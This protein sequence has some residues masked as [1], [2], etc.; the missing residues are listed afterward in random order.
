VLVVRLA[1]KA[2]RLSLPAQ[3]SPTDAVITRKK[4]TLRYG[5]WMCKTA[6]QCKQSTLPS[7]RLSLW[8]KSG[9]SGAWEQIVATSPLPM[10]VAL[11]F[12]AEIFGTRPPQQ[13]GVRPEISLP[14]WTTPWWYCLRHATRLLFTIITLYL[15]SG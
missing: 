1:S 13:C 6:V 10:W 8:V 9:N 7:T 5:C 15:E 3:V 11:G 4:T 2:T 12:T 14:S